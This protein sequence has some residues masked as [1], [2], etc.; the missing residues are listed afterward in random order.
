MASADTYCGFYR[1]WLI[2]N[3]GDEGWEMDQ[4]LTAWA[5]LTE[6]P[7]LVSTTHMMAHHY[8]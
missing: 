2:R 7:G 3:E 1:L 8:L 6:D 5:A 4:W